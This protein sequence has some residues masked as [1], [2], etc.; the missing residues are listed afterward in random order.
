VLKD[1]YHIPRN[2]YKDPLWSKK[3]VKSLISA[4]LYRACKQAG[5]KVKAGDKHVTG[6][7]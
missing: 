4:N 1:A 5:F 2:L 6:Q 7:K 3:D